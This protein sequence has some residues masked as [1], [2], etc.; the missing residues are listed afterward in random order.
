MKTLIQN[1][2]LFSPLSKHHL[3][4]MDVKLTNGIISAIG[5]N[6][7][8]GKSKIITGKDHI[9][10]VAFTDLRANFGEPGFEQNETLRSGIAAAKKEGSRASV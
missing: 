1:A 2:K 5:K 6:L 8:V 9:L 7:P 3:K 4:I 10:S